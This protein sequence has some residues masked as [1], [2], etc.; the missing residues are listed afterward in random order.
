MDDSAYPSPAPFI[1]GVARSG[2]TLLRL[3][4]DAHPEMAIPPETHFMHQL[5]ADDKPITAAEQLVE[6]ICSAFSWSDFGLARE[7]L[8]EAVGRLRPF[9]LAGGLRCFY[10]LY[11]SRLGKHRWGD[12][13]PTY[14]DILAA[15]ATA[16][17][18]AHIIHIIRDGRAVAASRM[19]MSFGPGPTIEAQANDWL[20]RIRSARAQA[21]Q[22]RHYLE[23]HYEQLVCEPQRVL[24]TVCSFIDLSFDPVMLD[25]HTTASQRLAE[26]TD[27]RG[28]DGVLLSAGQERISIHQKTREPPDQ[29][30]I[31]SWREVLTA[32]DCATFA[33][34]AGDL[35]SELGYPA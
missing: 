27:W 18:E 28:P 15:I 14:V 22:C 20:T 5:L 25:Y 26:F 9:T 4:L 29:S 10:R 34:I 7:A 1:L 8:D 12:K 30:R 35:L 17:P 16:L 21:K 3:M 19:P 32:A 33:T 2:T 6:T 24:E 13:T 23:I 31:E 11:S